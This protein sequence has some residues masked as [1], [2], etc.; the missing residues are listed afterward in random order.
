M[1]KNVVVRVPITFINNVN[2]PKP[3]TYCGKQITEAGNKEWKKSYDIMHWGRS[4]SHG[5]LNLWQ[6]KNSAGHVI[7]GNV[8]IQAPYCNQH[9]KG[10]PLFKTIKIISTIGFAIAGILLLLW[11]GLLD[12][13]DTESD[14]LINLLMIGIFPIFGGFLGYYLAFAINKLLSLFN[15]KFRDFPIT[16]SGHWGFSVGDVKITGEVGINPVGYEIQLSFLNIESAQRF[17]DAYPDSKVIKGE[18]LILANSS[19]K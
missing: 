13:S 10:I 15:P 2:L 9:I 16:E 11:T 1:D 14:R 3:C 19:L 12:F 17:L 5:I 4:R 6:T 7:K 18:K 8:T